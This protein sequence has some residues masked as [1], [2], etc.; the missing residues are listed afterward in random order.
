MD[1]SDVTLPLPNPAPRVDRVTGA[2][3]EA[4]LAVGAAAFDPRPISRSARGW[5]PPSVELLQ[6]LLPQYDITALIA[7]GGMGAV[8]KATQRALKRAVAIKVL[9]PEMGEDRSDLQF[10][11]RFQQEAQAMAQLSHPNIVAVFDAGEV[12]VGRVVP[13]APFP[14][15]RQ[16]EDS[17]PSPSASGERRLEDQPPYLRLLYFVMEYV[18]GTDVGRVIATEGR[19]DPQRAVQIVAAVCEALAFAHEGGIVHRDIK[20]SNIM[21]DRKGRVKVVDFGLAKTAS[22]ETTPMTRSD[23]A[24]GTPDFVAPEALIPGMEMD[25]R[26]DIYA[27]GVMLYQMLTGKIPRGRFELPS[28]LIPQVDV[29]FDAIVDRAMQTD[30]EKRYSTALEMKRDVECVF[31]HVPASAPGVGAGRAGWKTRLTGRPL[32]LGTAAAVVLVGATTWLLLDEPVEGKDTP[33]RKTSTAKAP[34]PGSWHLLDLDAITRMGG[35][36]SLESGGWYAMPGRRTLSAFSTP[37]THGGL[38]VELSGR[39]QRGQ[40]PELLLREQA[41]RNYN[42][43]LDGDGRSLVIQRYDGT[44]PLGHPER[45]RTLATLPLEKPV[46]AGSPY[47]LEFLAVGRR[48]IA[49]VNGATL[50]VEAVDAPAAGIAELYNPSFDTFRR[51]ERMNLDGLSEAEAVKAAGI[52]G[53]S[54]PK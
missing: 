7:R 42:A 32:L 17:A 52:G 31:Q 41:T 22:L 47:T 48:L 40:M 46:Q 15:A 36:F 14:V 49:R 1:D 20:P 34:A 38:R 18:E 16:A 28:G 23:V 33:G 43:Y 13:Q 44:L 51:L 30:R 25:G 54:L 35:G 50:E 19:I 3:A 5:E 8:Y 24:M 27:V 39:L 10:A 45:Y 9:P 29:R 26:A 2:E 6:G 37:I 53:E 21:I 12:V 4:L 11:A